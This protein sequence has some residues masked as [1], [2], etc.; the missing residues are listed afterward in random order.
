MKAG[1][2]GAGGIGRL[3]PPHPSHAIGGGAARPGGR[4]SVELHHLRY[5]VAVARTGSFTRAAALHHVAQPSLSQQIRRLEEELG[6]PLFDRTG[7]K[8][9]LTPVGSALLPRAERILAAVQ[10]AV[11]EVREFIGLERG[12]VVVGTTPISG[13]HLLPPVLVHF[14]RQYPGVMV[15]L[16]EES[17]AALLDLTLRGEV[18]VSLVTH[19]VRDPELETVPLITEDL[20]LAVPPGHRLAATGQV[21]LAAVAGE[22]FILLKEGMGFRNVVLQACAAAGFTPEPVFESSHIDT[23]QSLVA[24]GMGVTLVPRMTMVRDR[25]PA[26]VFLEL[27]PPRH[28]RTL[29]LAWRRGQYLSQA[30]R[31]FVETARQ[32]WVR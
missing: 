22:P 3:W 13:S 2:S 23:V 8:V 16:R 21:E 6:T 19:P 24:A 10:A 32:I 20:L 15:T 29:V 27:A 1:G 28:T 12:R 7:G 30:T 14:H 11:Q 25:T 31:A 18:D 9:R 26:P 17:T 5:F 4:G